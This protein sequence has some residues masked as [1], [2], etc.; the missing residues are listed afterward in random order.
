MV[1]L[2]FWGHAF[3]SLVQNGEALAIDPYLA[4][5]PIPSSFC[6]TLIC[7]T[8]GHADHLGEAIPL[9]KRSAAPILAVSELARYC[10]EQGA[11]VRPAQPGGR[12]TFPF[13][14]V[15][16]VPAIHGSSGPRGEYLGVAAGLLIE[17]FGRVFY[18]AGDTA[19]FSDM[20][21][22][23][24]KN[25]IF[26]AMLPIGGLYTMGPEDALA[27]VKLLEPE[28]VIPMHFGT[29][30]A[31]A[32]DVDA[33]KQLVEKETDSRCLVLERGQESTI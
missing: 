20:A 9:S 4:Q 33:F 25:P 31:I 28:I 5:G 6:P 2:K 8:H 7:V 27:A 3:F 10:K 18:H 19:L 1:D 26:V 22:L 23:K 29:F 32:Q 14:W 21:Q 13:G 11:D 17:W 15:E 24:R 16:L 30:A 12:I